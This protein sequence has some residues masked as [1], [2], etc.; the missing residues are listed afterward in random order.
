[1]QYTEREQMIIELYKERIQK[2]EEKILQLELE[3]LIEQKKIKN[4]EFLE[5][6]KSNNGNSTA[7]GK[8]RQWKD[9]KDVIGI[10]VVIK[11]MY[12]AEYRKEG[13]IKSKSIEGFNHYDVQ[14]TDGSVTREYLYD[15]MPIKI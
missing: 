4:L 7:L 15:L 13:T 9:I 3:K 11:W 1:M 8:C 6:L 14:W 10:R 5:G 12:H 2:L